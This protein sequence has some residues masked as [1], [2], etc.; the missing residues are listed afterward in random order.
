MLQLYE[1]KYP[2]INIFLVIRSLSYFK[3]AEL[4]PMPTMFM[5]V[6]WDEIK[7]TIRNAIE[8]F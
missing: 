5:D 4:D 7:S 3:D 6:S 1:K 2:H 8:N